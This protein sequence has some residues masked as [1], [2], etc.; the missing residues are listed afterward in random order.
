MSKRIVVL[1]EEVANQIAAGEVVERP[2][3][4]VKE[5]VENSIDA[6]ARDIHIELTKGGCESIRIV[7]NGSG[8]EREDMA[9]VFERHATSKISKLD[10]IY[11]VASFGFRGEAMASIASIARLEMLTRRPDDLEGTKAVAQAGAISEI[12]PAG[13]PPGTQITVTELFAN[14]PARRKFLKTEAT[15]QSACLD[16]ITRLA[17]PHPEVRFVVTTDGRE[18]FA[19]PIV[20]DVFDRV[21]MVMGNDFTSH[22]LAI[23]EQKENIRLKGFISTPEYTRSNSKSIFLFV[24]FRFI[25]DNSMTHA[26]LAAYRQVIEPRRY[27]AA[28][29]F[30]DLPGEEV[31]I[32][33]HPAK[34]EVRFRNSRE[35]YDL[36]SKT[37]ARSLASTQTSPDSF[38]Y[39]LAPRETSSAASGFWRP[40]DSYSFADRPL[41]SYSRQN[42][43]QAIDDDLFARSANP[44][45]DHLRVEEN[46]PGGKIIFANRKY[47]GQVADTYL[48]FGSQG[49]LMLVDQHAAHERVIL[50]RLKAS[51]AAK[52]V[53]QPLLM[54]EVVSVTPAQITLFESALSMLADIG[55]DLEIFGRDAI[56]VKAMPAS[57]PHVPPSDIISDL[58]D[59]LGDGQAQ[60]SLVERREKILASLACR[61]AIKAN[62]VLSAEEVSALCRDLEKTPFN[63]TCPHG[64][65]I[66][67]QF[68]LYEIERMFKRK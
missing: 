18:V 59:Q 11:R 4:I 26:V 28:V 61:A 19:A 67:V 62:K 29:L 43:R 25:R 9:L 44:S 20:R 63:A 17:L 46:S 30:L 31:D 33:V 22:C 5:L 47:L 39:R 8:I 56:V 58:A 35:I 7:D 24:N 16:A 49:G 64:R 37:V 34:L 51:S 38:A 32:N 42:L 41:E 52:A 1:S 21:G 12:S 15:E 10:D 50:E 48:V 3:S 65:P 2:A 60:A 57:L 14:V 54:P 53:G 68:S 55:L 13:L 23:S 66:S 27:P 6:G 40:K 36:V 45:N